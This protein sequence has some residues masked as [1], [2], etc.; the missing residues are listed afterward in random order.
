VL[1]DISVT[2]TAEPGNVVS[3]GGLVTFTLVVTNHSDEAATLDSLVDTIYGDITDITDEGGTA[4]PQESTD[5]VLPQSLA[6]AGEAGDSY[7]CSFVAYLTGEPFSEETNV[8]TATASDNDGNTDTDTDDATVLFVAPVMLTDSSLC[9]FDRIPETE[10]REFRLLLTPDVTQWPSYTVTASNPG[11]FFFNGFVQGTPG[12]QISFDVY[13]PYPFVT[14]GAQPVH[15]YDGVSFVY[16]ADPMCSTQLIPGAELVS[17]DA[18]TV[19]LDLSNYG[20]GYDASGDP[21]ILKRTITVTLPESPFASAFLYVNFH[22]DFDL[23][24]KDVDGPDEDTDPDRYD[25]GADDDAYYHGTVDLAIPELARHP[26]CLDPDAEGVMPSTCDE[27]YNDNEFKRIPG[28]G[29]LV[30]DS[31]ENL[32]PGALVRLIIP[33]KV[34]FEPKLLEATTDE[35]GWYMI[36]YKHKGKPTDE[37]LI[38]VWL[39]GEQTGV[40]EP[41]Y[42]VNVFL[43][44]NAYAEA[45]VPGS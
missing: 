34:K 20:D 9:V 29:G 17:V 6:P 12:E 38:Q 42:E 3:T 45:H 10:E 43:K 41:D 33:E 37:Y 25:K 16:S 8:V 24:G 23:K 22:L 18:G 11:Q 5:C 15:V 36:Q 14:Q 40:E 31:D 35:D 21:E 28:I 30:R 26:F 4:R 32:A 44:G 19:D 7:T 27:V 39:D 13:V 2:K 1:P